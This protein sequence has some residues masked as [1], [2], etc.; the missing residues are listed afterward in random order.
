MH[1]KL[2]TLLCTAFLGAGLVSLQCHADYEPM[3]KILAIVDNGVVTQSEFDQKIT[4]IRKNF[5]MSG[6]PEPPEAQLHQQVLD[7][8]ILDELQ[9]Q[10]AQRAGVHISEDRL[11][12]TMANIAERNGTTLQGMVTDLEAR[13]ESFSDM[14]EQVRNEL[15]IQQVQQ[16]N[17]RS[18]IQVTEKE[19]REY[20]SSIEGKDRMTTRYKIS[21]VMLSLPQPQP[22]EVDAKAE[23]TLANIAQ[24]LRNGLSTFTDYTGG[25]TINGFQISNGDLGL[26]TEEDIPSMFR[27][28]VMNGDKGDFSA[29]IRSG[30]G[31]HIVVIDEVTGKAQMVHQNHA[32]HILIKLSEVRTD[33]QAKRA[34]DD[35]HNRLQQGGDFTLLAKEYSEDPGSAMQGGDLGWSMPGQFVPEFE[36]TLAR[37]KDNE[38]SQPFKSEFGWHIMEKMGER[39]HNMT[40]ESR[41]N[42]AY[43]TL[44]ERKFAQ[45]LDNW[46]LKIRDEAFVEVK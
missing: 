24:S 17:L 9:L 10:M 34:I 3:D 27:D 15:T 12:Q 35:I 29:P 16:G 25:K 20:L 14:R 46:L 6:Q 30:G 1:K 19:V 31:W 32:R 36:E 39:V 8:L 23:K 45:E 18:R 11:T 42:Q 4:V 41:Q 44:Y 38:I 43:Q 13:G 2:K 7:R 21:H 33:R 5:E 26:R 37:L 22:A 28:M 40:E